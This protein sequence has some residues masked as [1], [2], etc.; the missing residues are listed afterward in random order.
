MKIKMSGKSLSEFPW[1]R[2]E[3]Q[4][5]FRRCSI[6]NAVLKNFAIFTGKYLC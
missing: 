5:L 2:H 4:V 1:M 3:I 6:I